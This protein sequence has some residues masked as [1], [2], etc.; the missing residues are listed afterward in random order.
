MTGKR[1]LGRGLAALLGTDEGGFEPS[2]LEL[3]DPVQ[4]PV[5]LIDPNPFQPRRQF[6]EAE[7]ARFVET[8]ERS[9][10]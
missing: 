8:S 3:S 7:L 10:A 1:R 2:S 9:A 5:D 4:L 6:D